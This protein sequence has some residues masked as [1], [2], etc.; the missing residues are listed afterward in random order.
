LRF[1][2][3]A[4]NTMNKLQFVI[5]ISV[6]NWRLSSVELNWQ[7]LRRSTRFGGIFRSPEFATKLRQM[8]A[9]YR[10]YRGNL[11]HLPRPLGH[12]PP[13]LITDFN[14]NI[15]FVLNKYVGPP[16]S[17]TE[18]LH[19][20]CMLPGSNSCRSVSVAARARLQQQTRRTQLLLSTDG[21]D[22]RTD[23]HSAVLWRLPQT[24]RTA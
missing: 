23:V 19:A 16:Y 21:T 7:Q 15:N 10:R 14:P 18:M 17:R 13:Y 5:F 24:T 22:R 6:I 9:D 12:M 8:K 1:W 4:V 20:A 11:G 2:S 3:D